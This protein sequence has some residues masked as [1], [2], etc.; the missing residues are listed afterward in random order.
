MT[1]FGPVPVS[2]KRQENELAFRFVVPTGI[3]ATLRLPDGD[4]S[5]LVLDGQRT[6]ARMQGRSVTIATGGGVHE[7]RLIVKP[8]PAAPPRPT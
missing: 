2:W 7:G 5:S 8:P 3:Q 1:E 4:P 6:Q